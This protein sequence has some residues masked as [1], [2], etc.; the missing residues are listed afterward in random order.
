MRYEIKDLSP[1]EKQIDLF[2]NEQEFQ[3]Y[4]DQAAKSLALVVKMPGFRKGKVPLDR[5]RRQFASDV[6]QMSAEEIV[7]VEVP[8]ILKEKGWKVFDGGLFLKK[9]ESSAR[10]FHSD[11]KFV[12]MVETLPAVAL[13]IPHVV[14]E[15]ETAEVSAGEVDHEVEMLRQQN[16]DLK[17]LQESRPSRAGDVLLLKSLSSE[18]SS[19]A[20]GGSPESETGK[21]L[22]WYEVSEK[23]QDRPDPLLGMRVGEI[24]TLEDQE[25]DKG[26]KKP[27]QVKPY[28]CKEIRVKI[29]PTVDDTLAQKVGK[30]DTLEALKHHIHNSLAHHKARE[31]VGKNRR[32]L[33]EQMVAANDLSVPSSLYRRILNE[34]IHTTLDN[35]ER[36]GVQLS[37][38]EQEKLIQES[39]PSFERE[40]NLYAKF[41]VFSELYAREH[42]VRVTESEVHQLVKSLN[43]SKQKSEKQLDEGRVSRLKQLLLQE[44]VLMNLKGKMKFK[45]AP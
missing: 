38:A 8:K 6:D 12:V 21:D 20:G 16:A 30:F 39:L 23:V 41:A 26:Q 40:A 3:A 37:Q 4:T 29:L 36:A 45:D 25:T 19:E 44:K 27:I 42:N 13:A 7:S 22:F 5:V 11:K 9:E 24:R 18:V 15:P 32:A 17:A 33:M 31:K 35:L 10:F 14:Q 1:V 28:L 43:P 2:P 34:Q